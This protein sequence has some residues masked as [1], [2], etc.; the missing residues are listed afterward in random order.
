MDNRTKLRIKARITQ[1]ETEQT[2]FHRDGNVINKLACDRAIH[3]LN[4]LLDE[5]LY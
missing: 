3:E 5:D 4:R 1:L 2:S